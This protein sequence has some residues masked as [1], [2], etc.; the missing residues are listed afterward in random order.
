M[1]SLGIQPHCWFCHVAAQIHFITLYYTTTICLASSS[2][3]SILRYF[4][5][6]HVLYNHS[7]IPGMERTTILA[8]KVRNGVFDENSQISAIFENP[9]LCNKHT[10]FWI[11]NHFGGEMNYKRE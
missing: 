10:A 1:S 3:N 5:S 7:T 2:A 6:L 11:S 8:K 4:E 9:I